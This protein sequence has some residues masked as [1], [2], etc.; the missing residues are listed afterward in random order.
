MEFAGNTLVF[1]IP[2]KRRS[3]KSP[4]KEG[5]PQNSGGHG[6]NRRQR[7]R[8]QV[9]SLKILFLRIKLSTGLL[10]ERFL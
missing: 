8:D 5:L 6:E 1:M 9:N 2:I 4:S 3:Y 7:D 10:Q